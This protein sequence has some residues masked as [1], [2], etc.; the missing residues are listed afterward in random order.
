[1]IYSILIMQLLIKYVNLDYS[2]NNVKVLMKKKLSKNFSGYIF[3]EQD[4]FYLNKINKAIIENNKIIPHF[5]EILNNYNDYIIHEVFKIFELNNN[6]NVLSL[7]HD[8][9]MKII[10]LQNNIYKE[11]CNNYFD[12]NIKIIK[13][14]Y[15]EE[16]TF[17][18]LFSNQDLIIYKL[19]LKKTRKLYQD[20]ILDNN[21]FCFFEKIYKIFPVKDFF[22]LS[23]VNHIFYTLD[24]HGKINF[25]NLKD[26]FMNRYQKFDII[27][28]LQ[29][30]YYNEYYFAEIGLRQ[31]FLI[32]GYD[33]RLVLIRVGGR[34][35][36]KKIYF[37]KNEKVKS[38]YSLDNYQILLGT[39][40]GNIYL[41]EVKNSLLKFEGV[42]H[43]CNNNDDVKLISQEKINF[44]IC[45]KCG[46]NYY[47]LIDIKDIKGKFNEEQFEIISNNEFIFLLIFLLVLLLLILSKNIKTYLQKDSEY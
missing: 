27:K 41:I 6:L 43:I 14:L 17:G 33:N 21:N 22:K 15:L 32:I 2:F 23:F 16:N 45:I 29:F 25:F 24:F 19:S 9:N 28:S 18:I 37:L 34:I 42:I 35:N 38:L 20:Y 11:I 1:M 7:S 46:D 47:K 36:I 31:R 44:L 8:N 3:P 39:D 26:Y 12:E 30:G 4:S 40:K 5:S 13:I 10:L